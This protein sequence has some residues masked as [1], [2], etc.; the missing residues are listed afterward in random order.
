MNLKK[1]QLLLLAL[2]CLSSCTKI[3]KNRHI[4]DFEELDKL[5]LSCINN[6]AFLILQSELV[7]K[8]ENGLPLLITAT[9]SSESNDCHNFFKITSYN[10]DSMST[11][12]VN[13]NEMWLRDLGPIFIYNSEGKLCIADFKW[14]QYGYEGYLSSFYGGNRQLIQERM[15]YMDL[16]TKNQMDSIIGVKLNLP[17]VSSWLAL[18]GGGIEGNGNGT[19]ILNKSMIMQRNPNAKLQ[20]IEKELQRVLGV[21][22]F[23]WLDFGLAEDVHI[24]GTIVGDYVGIGTGGHT[25]EFVRFADHKTILLAWIPEEEKDL[26]PVNQI[27]YQRMSENY[28]VL[29]KVKDLDGSNFKII[30]IHQPNLIYEKVRINE[31]NRL[32]SSLNLAEIHFKPSEN[33]Q[34][35]DSVYRVACASYLNFYL[36]NKKVIFQSY[37]NHGTAIEK[38]NKV[39]RI[40]KQV[41]PNREIIPIDPIALNWRGGGLHCA[42]L[43]QPNGRQ[44]P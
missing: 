36:T 32:D 13:G 15:S 33:R 44:L 7:N 31:G 1:V 3:S 4:A 30:K 29:S 16:K 34:A 8:H 17:I 42:T 6:P 37:I 28:Q 18:E 40:F 25:D 10:S 35:G 38:E 23:I 12:V 27:N 11:T 21:R 26:N 39:I 19:L 20:D 22:L 5:W 9:S 24:V 43:N 41:F 2:L 14:T